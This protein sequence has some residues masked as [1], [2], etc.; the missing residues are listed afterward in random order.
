MKDIDLIAMST[1]GHTGVG[2]WVLGS[3]YERILHHRPKPVLLVRAGKEK[4]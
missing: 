3:V 1:H 2:R 4:T